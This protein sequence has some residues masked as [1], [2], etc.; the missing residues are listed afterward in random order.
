VICTYNRCDLLVLALESLCRQSLSPE[1]YEILVVD[2]ASTDATRDVVEEARS[3][4]P[5]HRIRY[6]YEAVPGLAVARNAGL[7]Q[8]VAPL[9]AYLDDDAKAPPDWLERA[10]SLPKILD[11]MPICIGGPIAPFYTSPVPA[12]FRDRY[13]SRSWGEVARWLRVAE[14]FSGSNMIWD[15]RSL[16]EAGGFDTS[17]GVKGGLL[18]LGEETVVF[19]RIWKQDPAAKFYYDPA[20]VVEHWVPQSKMT[21][22]YQL[23]RAFARGRDSARAKL[24]GRSGVGRIRLL[25]RFVIDFVKSGLLALARFPRHGRWQ[26]WA[27]EEARHC[28]AHFGR[29]VTAL[30]VNVMIRQA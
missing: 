27:V 17:R 7:A 28:V 1:R 6:L 4:Y 13:E 20:L 14:S 10:L 5:Q 2:N 12:W 8:A 16:L 29:V 11:S 15:R 21:V 22:G 3:T 9:V 25:A 26:N 30:G 18:S 19:E 24:A 23:R